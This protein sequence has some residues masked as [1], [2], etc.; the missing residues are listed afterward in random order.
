MGNTS[1]Y[2]ALVTPECG[3]TRA[4][5]ALP[6]AGHRS[7][8]YRAQAQCVKACT[9]IRSHQLIITA[10]IITTFNSTRCEHYGS[11]KDPILEELLHY[12]CFLYTFFFFFSGWTIASLTST[13]FSQ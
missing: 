1:G 10:I 9:P 7:C 8:R 13:D 5:R 4:K 6:L 3:H 2:D 12:L 11:L